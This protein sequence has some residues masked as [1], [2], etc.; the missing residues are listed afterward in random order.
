VYKRLLAGAL[1]VFLVTTTL[2]FVSRV[3]SDPARRMLDIGA[4]KK[5]LDALTEAF[6][7]DR[8]LSLQY[9]EFMTNAIRLDFGDSL[10]QRRPA[11]DIVM[12]RLPAS[13]L[14]VSMSTLL[15]LVLFVP[16][17]FVAT[18]HAGRPVDK[19]VSTISLG[20][21]SI[22]PFWLG[23]ILILVFAVK[24]GWLPSFGSGSAKQMVLPVTTLAFVSGGRLLH[25]TRSVMVEQVGADYVRT[26]RAKGL[27]TA[28][29]V[30]K[31]VLRNVFIPILTVAAWDFADGL[32]GNVII[33]EAVFGRPGLGTLLLDAINRQ[34]IV[35]VEAAVFVI[36]IIVVVTNSVA[37]TLYRLVDPR[38]G[39]KR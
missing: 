29:I 25:L 20:G 36:T 21:V 32:A 10:S 13:L 2:F 5:Q 15:S 3:I 8:P 23:Q 24:F 1:V 31:H 18:I 38:T 28:Y 27:T 22:P 12:E 37:D 17:G 26:A 14:L 16:L 11:L 39:V 7:L 33:V 4:P 30:R 9:R 6:G 35:L 19:L 34:D